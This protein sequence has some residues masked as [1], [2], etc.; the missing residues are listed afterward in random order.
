MQG[1]WCTGESKINF[2]T[3]LWKEIRKEWEVI[4]KNAK[5]VIGDGSRVSFWKDLWCGEVALCMV[6]LTLFRLVVRKEALIREVWDILNEDR[7][8][9]CFSRPFND[10]EVTEVDNFLH[11]IQPWRVV[12]NME[13]KLILKGSN[14]GI[15]LV[16]L[17]CEVL[18]CPVSE[19]RPF[20]SLSVWN[21]LASL[22][23][24]F[25]VWKVSLGKVLT[26]DQL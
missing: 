13:D 10:W 1:G 20:L 24:G 22:K 6:Y 14:W 7:W 8:T 16:K 15:Y 11:T 18:N 2:G 9:P 19:S 25:F 4:L 21:P 23:V 12:S 17:M 26:L 5:F 3:G